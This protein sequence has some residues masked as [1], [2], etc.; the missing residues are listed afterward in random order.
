MILLH[1]VG[2][3]GRVLSFIG[4]PLYKRGYEI[5]C[6]D[7]PGYGITQTNKNNVDYNIWV[8][9]VKDL[10]EYESQKDQK[11][12]LLF[13]LSAGGMLA[14]HAGCNN[15]HVSG[16][17]FTNL[18]DQRLQEVRD[19][20]ESSKYISRIGIPLLYLLKNLNN[21]IKLPMKMVANMKA[22]VNNDDALNLLM[23]DDKSSGARVPVKLITSMIDY[24]PEVEPE[25]FNQC[26]A[27]LVHPEDDRWT[28]IRLSMLTF[29]KLKCKKDVKILENSGHFPIENPGLSQLE[30]YIVNFIEERVK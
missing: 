24:K 3:N 14:Y 16:L 9:M 8:N 19:F 13:G 17:I 15:K 28:D 25:D 22:I 26:P 23:N 2:G 20:S 6:P 12:V 10:V 7:L 18:L 4:V 29:E 27:L 30:E 11:D 5:V 21:K 1:G